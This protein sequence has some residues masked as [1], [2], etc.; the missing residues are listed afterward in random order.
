MKTVLTDGSC[1]ELKCFRFIQYAKRYADLLRYENKM[2]ISI[3]EIRE[4]ND[5]NG[6]IV[7]VFNIK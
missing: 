7:E 2:N 1:G 3:I 4:G 6:P 5:G